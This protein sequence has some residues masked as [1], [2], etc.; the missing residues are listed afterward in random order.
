MLVPQ[1][2]YPR[3]RSTRLGKIVEQVELP[4]LGSPW[5]LHTSVRVSVNLGTESNNKKGLR[6]AHGAATESKS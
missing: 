1:E 5:L 2:P 6:R 3:S 4:V